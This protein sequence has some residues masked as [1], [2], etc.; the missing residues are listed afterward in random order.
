[1]GVCFPLRVGMCGSSG[2]FFN[3]SVEC[4]AKAFYTFPNVKTPLL[5]VYFE[6]PEQGLSLFL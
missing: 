2:V 3:V 1:M 6:N 4:I 5:S